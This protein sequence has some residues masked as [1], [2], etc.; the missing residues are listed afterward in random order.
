M[1]RARLLYSGSY[2]HVMNRG[3]VGSNIFLGDKLKSYFLNFLSKKSKKLKIRLLAYCI[4]D[5]HYH[6]IL[7]NS[8]GKLSG[9]MKQLNGH[10]GIIYRKNKGERGYVFQ[11]RYK[12]TLIQEGPYLRMSIVYVL[13]NPV[14]AG[15]VENP[16]DYKWSSIGE[17]FI[18]NKKSIVDKVFIE[19]IFQSK[20]TFD[21]LLGE[22]S[23]K[24]LPV[25]R[26]R[27]GPIIGGEDFKEEAI[28]R[29]DRRKSRDE[30]KRMRKEDYILSPAEVVI[31]EFENNKGIKLKEIDV[32]TLK[33][34]RLR[35]ELLVL[36]K[37]KTG[38]TY[39]KIIEYPIFHSLKYSSLGHLYK[40]AK[41][42][43]E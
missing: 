34:K 18:D 26:T 9:F 17:Y 16:Y 22:W 40:R 36:L 8:S 32:N 33:G 28:K 3:L 30:S 27:F 25:K 6:L 11:G 2:H 39:K 24:D 4:M 12:S 42:V 35:S 23:V 5:N 1:R 31:R 41:S 20:T 14:R 7:Q 37:D 13:L 19:D 29:Y 21:E 43:M 15:L 38:L 10:Y